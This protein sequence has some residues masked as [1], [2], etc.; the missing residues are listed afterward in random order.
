MGVAVRALC[1][2]LDYVGIDYDLRSFEDIRELR[3]F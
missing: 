1:S 3:G 2:V